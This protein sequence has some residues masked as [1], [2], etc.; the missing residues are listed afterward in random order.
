MRRATAR[1]SRALLLA[2]VLMVSAVLAPGVGGAWQ[3]NLN[4][5]GADVAEVFRALAEVSGLNIVLDPS[6]RGTLTVKLQDVEIDEALKLVPTRQGW[7]HHPRLQSDSHA[8][9]GRIQP[10]AP[11]TVQ[12]PLKHARTGD[13]AAASR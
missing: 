12:L 5:V 3:V 4:L 10:R 13:V 6:V 2:L 1:K 11:V 8:E 9:R 7:R